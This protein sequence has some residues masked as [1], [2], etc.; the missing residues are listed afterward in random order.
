MGEKAKTKATEKKKLLTR[1]V[2]LSFFLLLE[3]RS[4]I[5]QMDGAALA[6]DDLYVIILKTAL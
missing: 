1:L 3:G 6:G 2:K 4:F 5:T